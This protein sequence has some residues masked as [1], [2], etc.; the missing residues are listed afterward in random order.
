MNFGAS[1]FSLAGVPSGDIQPMAGTVKSYASWQRMWLAG[2]EG[3]MESDT[4]LSRPLEQS[5]WVLA[6]ID[7]VVG[8]I[9]AQPLVWMKDAE[10]MQALPPDKDRAK[11]WC[12]PGRTRAGK[13]S[14]GDVVE[15]AGAWLKLRGICHF[16]L[17]DTWLMGRNTAKAPFIIARPDR[18]RV[19][20]EGGPGGDVAGWIWT[21][22]RGGQH[23][24]LPQQVVT[25]RKA[26]P[27]DEVG[28]LSAY[29]PAS[30][31]AEADVAAGRFAKNVAASNGQKGEYIIA[32]GGSPTTEQREQIV[33]ALTEKKRR[34]RQGEFAPVF[35][36]GGLRIEEAKVSSVDAAFVSQRI[37][38]R[39]E[40]YAA[41]GVPMSLADVK[42][43]YS[44]G[45][46]SDARQ[47]LQG[48]SMPLARKLASAFAEIEELRSGQEAHA[49]FD[50][51]SHPV[52]QAVL[53]SKLSS[54][55]LLAE[56]GV[57][58]VEINKMLDLGLPRFLGDDVGFVPFGVQPMADALGAEEPAAKPTVTEGNAEV[59]QNGFAAI[60]DVMRKAIEHRE[61]RARILSITTTGAKTGENA[62]NAT[63]AGRATGETEEGA[64]Q[65]GA[66]TRTNLWNRH[67]SKRAPFER[68]MGGALRKVFGAA[69]AKVLAALE[70]LQTKQG[71]ALE[72]HAT[73]A[74]GY[75]FTL[76]L[77]DL[78]DGMWK[79]VKPVLQGALQKAGTEL[80]AEVQVDNVFMMAPKVAQAFLGIREN[81]IKDAGKEVFDAVTGTLREGFDAGETMD[82][83]ADRVRA[84]FA[85]I[86]KR[87]AE[88]IAATETA[89]AYGVARHAA[90]EQAGITHKEWLTAKDDRVRSEHAAMDGVIA[91][92]D[93]PFILEDGTQL[94]HPAE[95]G[96]PPQHV[97]NCRCVSIAA[98]KAPEDGDE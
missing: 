39:H 86:S 75:D 46:D 65:L 95:E 97:I 51:V 73:K 45:A 98:L 15:L 77:G 72:S 7:L 18:M 20:E 85:G 69:R 96:G 80:L 10:S 4:T 78:Q 28:G 44:I 68:R 49:A 36:S 70:K 89:S 53:A 29:A 94:M 93:Q 16:I 24:L 11:W 23:P 74:G 27:F 71:A 79:A 92:I 55:S 9:T 64:I 41:F 50:F 88:T 25:I 14:L 2:R 59:V 76:N 43:A 81:R 3:S 66:R 32:E 5:T 83:L 67:Q 33:A 22:A 8:Q 13:L 58:M 42:A 87:R 62:E 91:E 6:A 26:N 1:N 63:L 90:M 82:Q 17:D 54:V 19:L 21:D 48:A 40:I 31:A 61:K 57:P 34:V 38:N 30:L 35:L 52:V 47:L 12:H 84:E 60:A 37:E 56:R